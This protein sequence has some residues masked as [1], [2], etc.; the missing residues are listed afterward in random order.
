MSAVGILLPCAQYETLLKD[1]W[2]MYNDNERDHA[3][4]PFE[5]RVVE[6][7]LDVVR[8]SGVNMQA[9]MQCAWYLMC[10]LLSRCCSKGTL[11]PSALAGLLHPGRLGSAVQGISMTVS[12]VLR[13]ADVPASGE[14]DQDHRDHYGA[15]VSDCYR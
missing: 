4:M 6:A 7:A 9:L 13:F 10:Y 5:L 8:P 3:R 11:P 15:H 2:E 12:T 14:P 1:D